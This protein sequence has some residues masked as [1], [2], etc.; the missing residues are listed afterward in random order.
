MGV[1]LALAVVPIPGS[2]YSAATTWH[3]T[4]SEARG[5]GVGYGYAVGLIP[6]AYAGL[7]LTRVGPTA[8]R[9]WLLAVTGIGAFGA[10]SWFDPITLLTGVVK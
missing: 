9:L 3:Y 1:A 8:P 7:L 6:L 10:V 2:G 5:M 4:V